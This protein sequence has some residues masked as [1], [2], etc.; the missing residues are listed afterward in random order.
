MEYVI[1]IIVV[2]VIAY[3]VFFKKDSSGSSSSAPVGGGYEGS[4]GQES[5]PAEAKAEAPKAPNFNSMTKAQLEAY[6]KENFGVDIDLRKKKASLI[7]ELQNL[8]KK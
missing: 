3:F 2:A 5:A 6:G 1:G 8:E 4:G 7:E